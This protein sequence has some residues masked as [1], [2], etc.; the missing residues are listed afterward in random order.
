MKRIFLLLMAFSP[1]FFSCNEQKKPVKIIFD[2]DMLTDPEDVNALCL[3]N[4]F[5]DAGEAEILAC[6][7]NGYDST[8]AS[9]AAIDVVNTFYNRPNIP[10]GTCKVGNPIQKSTYT[11]LLRD[12]F[13]ND[14]PNDDKLP[15]A[16]TVY[17]Q[18]LSKAEDTSVVI[19]TIGYLTNMKNLL[20][21]KPDSFSDMDGISLVKKK[22]K[23]LVCMAGAFPS[24]WEYNVGTDPISSKYTF[25]NWP[26]PIIFSGAEIGGHIISG[27]KYKNQLPYCPLL[28]AL[29]NSCNA[30][31]R[32]R[33]SWDETAV[34]Y[35]IRGLSHDGKEYW[36]MQ[37]QG[38][39]FINDSDGTNKWLLSPDKDQSYLIESMNPDS[40]AAFMENLIL[41]S[42]KQK[43]KKQSL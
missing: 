12:S 7:T 33:E 19:V 35:G 21:S 42:I 28:L 6:V 29:K 37:S 34:I 4:A 2:T 15:D 41:N 26:R 39:V 13:P 18:M 10:I 3:L 24:G 1:L 14:V 9:G 8:R 43:I 27:K 11:F 23:K 31:N 40:V 36:K 17:R 32:G 5:A 20:Q 16:L 22:V 25:E 38:S 30:I